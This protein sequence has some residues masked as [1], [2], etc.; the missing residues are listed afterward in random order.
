MQFRFV[1]AAD[2]HLD[3]PLTGAPAEGGLRAIF[4][5]ATFAALTRIADLCIAQKAD[6]L[7]LAGDLFEFRDRSVRA[8]L[9][10]RRELCRLHGAGIRS[11]IVHGNHDPLSNDSGMLK[12]PPSAHVFGPR[13]EEI[14]VRRAGGS[15]VVCRVQGVSYPEERVGENLSRMF[16]RTGPEFTIGAL[17]ANLEGRSEH[18]NYAPCTLADLS[19]RELDYWALGHVH[20]RA[21]HPLDSGGIA[22][23]PGNPQGRHAGETG[24]RGCVVVDV[25]EGR[26]VRRF[27]AVDSVR[28]HRLELEVSSIQSLDA[29]LS[30]MEET[31]DAACGGGPDAHAVRVVLT[32]EGPLHHELRR[33]GAVGDLEDELRR[34]SAARKPP[35]AVESIVAETSAPLEWDAL[36]ASGGLAGAIVSAAR[37]A[38]SDGGLA[39]SAWA[40]G[41]LARLESLL[42]RAGVPSPREEGRKVLNRA[43]A[44]ALELLQEE[45]GR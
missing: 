30:A 34:S 40:G 36:V 44:R 24:E 17:H 29:L 43:V 10:L 8:R 16:H 38:R 7:I 11:F 15:K 27:F 33:P 28:W 41:D 13:W 45:A 26:S 31:V 2:L 3:S 18:P 9:A 19:Q 32:G 12:L 42:R 39:A 22:V 20:T 14:E 25:A 23:Y 6:F 37:S 35:V 1:H 21:E 4:E 5:G